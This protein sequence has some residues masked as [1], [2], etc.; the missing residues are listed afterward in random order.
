MMGIAPAS[1]NQAMKGEGDRGKVIRMDERKY[2]QVCGG[3]DKRE[4]FQRAILPVLKTHALTD[5][6]Q[7]SGP[8]ISI[9]EALIKLI[10]IVSDNNQVT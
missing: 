5:S 9:K 4:V 2:F 8:L 7:G 3:L 10:E 1:Y 6:S